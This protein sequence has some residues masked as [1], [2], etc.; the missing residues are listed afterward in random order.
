MWPLLLVLGALQEAPPPS[1]PPPADTWSATWDNRLVVTAPGDA[2]L[3]VRGRVFLEALVPS[4]T[5]QGGV[6][7]ENNTGVRSARIQS[8][9]TSPRWLV[10]SQWEFS[11][12]EADWRELY[13]QTEFEGVRLRGGHHREPAGLE[14]LQGL[15]FNSFPER[16][17]ASEAF[18]PGR[19]IG[20]TLGTRSGAW[21]GWAGVYREADEATLDLEGEGR[22]ATTRLAWVQGGT[23]PEETLV[24]LAG[25]LSWRDE[26]LEL[27]SRAGNNLVE[28]QIDTGNLDGGQGL[29]GGLEAAWQKDGWTLTGEWFAAD[30]GLD[31]GDAYLSGAYLEAAWRP[32]GE[33]RG[34]ARGKGAFRGFLPKGPKGAVELAARVGHT[35]LDGGS[36]RGGTQNDFGFGLNFQLSERSRWMLHW[37]QTRA[38][39]ADL[40]TVFVRLQVGL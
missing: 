3:L 8:L 10:R 5:L 16:S 19:N 12:G 22:S 37:Q 21:S 15:P 39:D 29:F 4:G 35:D 18:T 34:Y 2:V 30:I 28:R 32:G 7:P 24:H 1:A 31:A 14:A 20:L 17:A 26:G 38:G 25:W 11:G 27:R 6:E 36:V 13:A 23:E 40:R 9:F 33:A